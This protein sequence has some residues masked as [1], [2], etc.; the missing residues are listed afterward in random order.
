M[1]FFQGCENRVF[2]AFRWLGEVKAAAPRNRN[3]SLGQTPP[4]EFGHRLGEFGYLV[5]CVGL[6]P[7]SLA[8]KK[9]TPA[10]VGGCRIQQDA[11]DRIH[12]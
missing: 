9:K 4:K 7:G 5:A 11:M 2:H 8:Q 12:L 3:V 1:P 6:D 10:T